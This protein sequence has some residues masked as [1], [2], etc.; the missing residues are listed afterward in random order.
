MIS[1]SPDYWLSDKA[2]FLQ[3]TTLQVETDLLLQL[4]YINLLICE[5]GSAKCTINFRT[6]ILKQGDIL[7]V[8][9]DALVILKERSPDFLAT[10]CFL[11]REFAAEIAYELP[12]PLFNFLHYHPL[13]KVQ[14]SWIPQLKAWTTQIWFIFQ[15]TP[16][17][18]RL[19]LRNHLQNLFLAIVNLAPEDDLEKKQKQSRQE[20][21]CW[22][23]WELVSQHAK[24]ER[25]VQF[26]A[27]NLA[28]TP[29]YLAKISQEILNDTPKALIDRQVILEI[30]RLLTNTRYSIEKI[31]E[32]LNFADP[33][34]LSRYFKKQTKMTLS[35]FR[36]QNT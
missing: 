24:S 28:I 6:Y 30:K 29:Y 13:L 16:K 26:Y 20:Q 18:Q 4:A 8:A 12:H 9:D 35:E 19:M 36:K 25:S 15:S 32:S 2:F 34:Y 14:P 33:S 11:K 21:I 1:E 31:A 7:F 17:Y 22:K 10:G 27:K 5:S 3:K 23:F